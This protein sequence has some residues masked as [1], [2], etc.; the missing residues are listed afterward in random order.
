MQKHR[1]LIFVFPLLLCS[2]GFTPFALAGETGNMAA[3]LTPTVTLTPLSEGTPEPPLT[4]DG[5]SW[6]VEAVVPLPA[7]TDGS[8]AAPLDM[9]KSIRKVIEPHLVESRVD[10]NV[11]IDGSPLSE[12]LFKV[13]LS[14]EAGSEQFRQTLFNDINP[15]V[16]LLG[17]AVDLEITG[18]AL[19][20]KPFAVRLESNPTT[21]NLWRVTA[22]DPA[23]V[24]VLEQDDFS[25]KTN[26]VGGNGIQT[27]H[28]D[29]RS[30][31]ETMIRLSYGRPWESDDQ[32][33]RWVSLKA[34]D[35]NR[36]I[37]LSSPLAVGDTTVKSS[38]AIDES[39]YT[40]KVVLPDSFDWHAK[41][42][43]T[44]IRDQLNC[45]SCWAFSTV[46]L[47]EAA[48]K[49][50]G[51]G[52]VDLSEQYLIDCNS[53]R[54]TCVYGGWWAHDYFINKYITPQVR[55]GAVLENDYPY[56]ADD[57]ACS[58][59]YQHPYQLADWYSVAGDAMPTVE[60]IKKAIYKYG[61]VSAAVCVSN[62]FASYTGGVFTDDESD[63]C[64]KH[65][66]NHAIVL[67]GWD[68]ATRTWVL[69]NSWG[70]AWGE[71]GYMR[72]QWGLSNVGYSSNYVVYHPAVPTAGPSPTSSPVPSLTPTPPPVDNDRFE[73]ASLIFLDNNEFNF[74]QNTS[75]ATTGEDDPVLKCIGA[76]GNK[77]VWYK[78]VP[79]TS[80]FI[81]LDTIGSN[82]DTVLGVYQGERGALFSLACNDDGGGHKAS[83]IKTLPVLQGQTYYIEV[84]GLRIY[85][86]GL[87]YLHIQFTP[88]GSNTVL[89][90]PTTT[91]VP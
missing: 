33:T 73:N 61:P 87:M 65:L 48:I 57:G 9:A 3:T 71:E 4:S 77:S 53:N 14:G 16:N 35:L 81:N 6:S 50:Q 66:I 17:G 75:N 21:G 11:K 56:V 20:G 10:A 49:I 43:L 1:L 83:R 37:D 44:P 85:T 64:G 27:L 70:T 12:T 88:E 42:Q 78:F 67:T 52:D 86:T 74:F 80:G 60:Q 76:I 47:M 39:L 23:M 79:Q 59:P 5:L 13:S 82:Y 30:N 51:G 89:P 90:T 7:Y 45:N 36:L 68:N 15:Q 34:G 46:G 18:Q 72:I 32:T 29:G 26:I 22:Y 91:L 25:Q 2:L 54:Y 55:A 63:V 69:R 84:T 38:P 62:E 58:R 31:G 24:Q 8:K 19:A 41:G 28:F 40:Q